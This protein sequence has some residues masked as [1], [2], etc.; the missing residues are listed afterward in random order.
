MEDLTEYEFEYELLL[1]NEYCEFLKDL[2]ADDPLDFSQGSL[3]R[4]VRTDPEI[5][6]SIKRKSEAGEFIDFKLPDDSHLPRLSTLKR[7]KEE[8]RELP[9]DFEPVKPEEIFGR[10]FGGGKNSGS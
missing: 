3:D 4:E 9:D 1:R 5:Y 8:K 2:R 7:S 6:N 10:V